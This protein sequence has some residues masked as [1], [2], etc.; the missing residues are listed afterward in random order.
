MPMTDFL[1]LLL[2][3]LL[4]DERYSLRWRSSF[5]DCVTQF[6]NF[7]SSPSSSGTGKVFSKFVSLSLNI[8]QTL[9]KTT[10]MLCWC[11]QLPSCPKAWPCCLKRH[12][13]T[14]ACSGILVCLINL[15]MV[16]KAVELLACLHPLAAVKPS[17][18]P[19]SYCPVAVGELMVTHEPWNVQAQIW[20][21]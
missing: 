3:F 7:I 1:S 4:L 5:L 14:P 19:G 20:C 12:I 13:K 2:N 11:W 8:Y 6:F 10:S 9:Y 17:A 21:W 16:I 15:L 18:P